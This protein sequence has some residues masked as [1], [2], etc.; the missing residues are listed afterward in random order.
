CEAVTVSRNSKAEILKHLRQ[1]HG[2]VRMLTGG[3][4]ELRHLVD[5]A[6]LDVIT[7][8]KRIKE[9]EQEVIEALPLMSDLHEL[10]DLRAAAHKLE[11]HLRSRDLQRPI[12][13]VQRRIEGQI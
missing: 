9:I 2:D 5:A 3:G 12:L 8:V 10:D 6:I 13:G 4:S 11:L 7:L 1:T